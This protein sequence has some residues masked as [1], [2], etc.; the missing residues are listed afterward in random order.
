MA[1][2]FWA[3]S[4]QDEAGSKKEQL[5]GRLSELSE[6][7]AHQQHPDFL[8]SADWGEG[9]WSLSMGD[10]IAENSFHDRT[11]EAAGRINP[12]TDLIA[13]L[14]LFALSKII[15]LSVADDKGNEINFKS[16]KDLEAIFGGDVFVEAEKLGIWQPL[17]VV[18]SSENNQSNN[19]FF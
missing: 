1:E 11:L 2:L 12:G 15:S 19:L 14:V 10:G 18:K 13:G 9:V 4:P 8:F 3:V 5:I 17:Q 7:F 16:I 6:H